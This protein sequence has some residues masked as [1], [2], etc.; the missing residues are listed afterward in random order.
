MLLTSTT[1]LEGLSEGSDMAWQKFDAFYRPFL[2]CYAKR[3][4]MT[5]DDADD[6]VQVT[7]LE[8]RQNFTVKYNRE[9]GRLRHWVIGILKRQ[10]ANQKRQNAKSHVISSDL[11]AFP[12][13]KVAGNIE[14]EE[15]KRAIVSTAIELLKDKRKCRLTACKVNAFLEFTLTGK[16]AKEVADNLGMSVDD[17]FRS[18]YLCLRYLKKCR[19]TLQRF[20]QC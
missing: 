6:V 20:Y 15:W 18:K 1:L 19:H 10:I 7:M 14:E 12:S 11:N 13:P 4:G 5:D 17:V 16:P 9:Q 8:F 2:T 3:Y